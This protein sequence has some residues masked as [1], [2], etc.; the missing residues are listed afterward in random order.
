[1]AT[2]PDLY[3]LA[4][5]SPVDGYVIKLV[6]GTPTWAPD[7][8]AASP[9][10]TVLGA[11]DV[12]DGHNIVLTAGDDIRGDPITGADV[13]IR[14][15][16]LAA[17]SGDG[18]DTIIYGGDAG[19]AGGN[20]GDVLLLG[21][22]GAVGG[23]IRITPTAPGLVH[24]SLGLVLDTNAPLKIFDLTDTYSVGFQA[25]ATIAA[26]LLWA[27]PNTDSTGSQYLRSDGAGNLSWGTPAGAGG[28]VVGPASSTNN[29]VVRFDGTSGTSIKN[30]GV[31]VSDTNQIT[32][33]V[34]AT[35]SSYF[36]VGGASLP[37]SGAFRM[38][39]NMGLY[40]RTVE[41]A[42]ANIALMNGS[43]ILYLGDSNS[44]ATVVASGTSVQSMISGVA[45]VT[46][47]AAI[48]TFNHGAAGDVVVGDGYVGLKTAGELRLYDNDDSNYVGFKSPNLT[49]NQIWTLPATDSTGVQY[50]RSSGAGLLSWGTVGDVVGPGS[51]TD[52]AI[53]RFDLATG[54]LIQNSV[55][56]VSDTGTV[57]GAASY[58]A[59]TFVSVGSAP[60]S[61]G[62][63]RG[64]Y[65]NSSFRSRNI[66][67]TADVRLI[68]YDGGNLKV[69][70]DNDINVIEMHAQSGIS[71]YLA[72]AIAHS[73]DTQVV[74][75]TLTNF[76]SPYLPS[77]GTYIFYASDS[78][79]SGS[80]S[81]ARATVVPRTI[82]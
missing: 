23:S 60:A 66:G 39:N 34:T 75:H 63:F 46:S 2:R 9:L 41:G 49:S 59:S 22:V 51:S 79:Y 44:A 55:V 38:G 17:G 74:L 43:N 82:S 31:I 18:G 25:P 68:A 52:N 69:G 1:M 16:T 10:S 72:T 26:D 13:V 65:A 4:V 42:D 35:A 5:G 77:A 76:S 11:G 14:G 8:G 19:P 57:A 20:G 15:G 61:T 53:V 50:L 71:V 29:A 7:A 70:A 12:T 81:S 24:V 48:T 3:Q 36:C 78:A 47:I 58:A 28:D 6:S 33:I 27:L 73:M 45:V 67:D 54:K 37:T 62:T 64:S 21:G 30:S 80:T 40:T 56:T 32:G